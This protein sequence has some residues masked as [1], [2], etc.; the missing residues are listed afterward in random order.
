MKQYTLQELRSN[1]EELGLECDF[2][3]IEE[4][5]Q[6]GELANIKVGLCY[7]IEAQ[8]LDDF[9]YQFEWEGTA[10]EKGIG[11]AVK[12]RRLEMEILELRKKVMRMHDEKV[13]LEIQLGVEVF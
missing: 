3:M 1:L 9:I 13:K 6:T 4:W 7:Q 10:Y 12:I 2:Q 5:L 11:D 8:D